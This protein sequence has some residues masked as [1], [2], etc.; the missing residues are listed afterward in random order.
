MIMSADE[1][2]NFGVLCTLMGSLAAVIG[3]AVG[4][5]LAEARHKTK[6]CQRCSHP[7]TDQIGS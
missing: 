2:S 3:I 1:L 4:S 7:S 6:G 5:R